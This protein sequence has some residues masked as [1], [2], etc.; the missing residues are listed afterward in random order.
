MVPNMTNT[1]LENN[2]F[3]FS[4]LSRDSDFIKLILDH[5]SDCVVAIDTHGEI[6]Y[7]N[8]PYCR[9]LGGSQSEYIG[10]HISESISPDS[11]LPLVA[12]TGE[13]VVGALLVRGHELF[14]K[15]VP[16][17]LKGNIIGAVGL[18]LFSDRKQAFD[19]AK[20]IGAKELHLK[21][22]STNWVAKYNIQDLVGSCITIKKIKE[23][24]HKASV[25]NATVLIQGETGTGKELVANAIH[26]LS[27][28]QSQP[29]VA[30]NCATI[31]GELLE[32]ELFGYEG[33]AF[34]GARRGGSLGKFEIAKGGT[35]FLDEIGDLPLT[36][37]A[38]LLRVLQEKQILR[39]GG[40]SLIDVDVKVICATHRD[41]SAMVKT[42][43]FRQDL[44]YRL[45]I[46]RIKLPPLR[47]RQDL[48]QLIDHV[49]EKI[50][51]LYGINE[52]EINNDARNTLLARKWKGNIR[53]LSNVIERAIINSAPEKKLIT[54]NAL[55]EDDIFFR[56]DQSYS[57]SLSE[58]LAFFEKSIIKQTLSDCG[59]NRSK[60]AKIL[61]I[62]R[63]TLYNKLEKL[64]ISDN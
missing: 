18:A 6:I 30:V 45:D 27:S 49:F 57:S 37:Q 3:D 16:V 10:K 51:L 7:I 61:K 58:S 5:I 26:N 25:V 32:S 54:H 55:N 42:G 63:T 64:N 22:T 59:G 38:A 9:L 23:Q 39:V 34:T 28:R 33:G 36:S 8:Q 56:E 40:S 47:E 53:E 31:P 13:T 21:N 4:S 35:I 1:N 12:K 2:N 20:N 19:F 43:E 11:K 52:L 62:D 24:I 50:K 60:A 29:F 41:L 17:Y 44:Y 15:Q 46:L 14:T 48:S